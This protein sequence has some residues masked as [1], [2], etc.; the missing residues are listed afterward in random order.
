MTPTPLRLTLAAILAVSTSASALAEVLTA[1][2]AAS[3]SLK[4]VGVIDL[5]HSR[6]PSPTRPL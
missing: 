6:R 5:L 3:V 4:G 2:M 1:R